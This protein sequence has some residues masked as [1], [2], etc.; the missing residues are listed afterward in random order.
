MF[1]NRNRSW[2]RRGRISGLAFVV[3]HPCDKKKSQGWG[4]EQKWLGGV[5]KAGAQ[6]DSTEYGKRG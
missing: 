4:T 6:D 2:Q 1:I 3:S 5:Q